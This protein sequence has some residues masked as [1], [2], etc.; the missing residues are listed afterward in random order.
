MN[1]N[2]TEVWGEAKRTHARSLQIGIKKHA[3][4][5]ETI[6]S[7][8]K[9]DLHTVR[10]YIKKKKLKHLRAGKAQLFLISHINSLS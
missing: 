9:I 6:F 8:L 3:R 10:K 5:P 7:S 1:T 4:V 2:I